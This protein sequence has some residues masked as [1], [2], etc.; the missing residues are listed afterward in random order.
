LLM[1]SVSLCSKPKAW[2]FSTNIPKAL[3]NKIML[4]N[5]DSP[6][7][8]PFCLLAWKFIQPI[9]QNFLRGRVG[10]ATDE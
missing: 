9:C 4:E 7:M 8:K 3:T 2:N 5:Q 10:H 6:A 1:P